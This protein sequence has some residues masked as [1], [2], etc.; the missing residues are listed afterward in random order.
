MNKTG[1]FIHTYSLIKN[2]YVST[3]LV[4][5]NTRA[6]TLKRQLKRGSV[7]QSGDSHS[8]GR[9]FESCS[10]HFVSATPRVGCWI[11]HMKSAA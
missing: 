10:G 8:G 11:S 7:A 2:S 9:G 5:H 3:N 6:A 4:N 1:F